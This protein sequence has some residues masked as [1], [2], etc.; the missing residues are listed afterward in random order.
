YQLLFFSSQEN[1]QLIKDEVRK[2]NPQLHSS[3]PAQPEDT[4]LAPST[5]SAISEPASP[6]CAFISNTQYPPWL[7][8][9][10]AESLKPPLLYDDF[11]DDDPQK[12]SKDVAF[13]QAY[14]EKACEVLQVVPGKVEEF[15]G[16]LY[17]FERDPE[18]RTS[19]E[20]FKR[21]KPVLKDWPE[22]LS[23]FAA[24]LHPEQANECGLVRECQIWEGN[25]KKSDQ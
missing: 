1:L 22:L 15:L 17:E 14:L 19:V 4:T 8:E 25:L 12:D 3:Q 24:F 7:P 10:L 2:F 16:V 5:I 13:A 20:L 21:L 11:S 23:D 6:S 9:T 18:G